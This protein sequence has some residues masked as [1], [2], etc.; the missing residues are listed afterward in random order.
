MWSTIG[1]HYYVNF[2]DKLTW[3]NWVYPLSKKLDLFETFI[4]FQ[5]L[6][7]LQ[8]DAKIKAFPI[9]KLTPSHIELPVCTS[10]NAPTCVNSAQLLGLRGYDN[11]LHLKLE[12]IGLPWRKSPLEV[13]FVVSPDFS[14]IKIFDSKCFPYFRDYRSRKLY[15]KSSPCI[16][17]D[18]PLTHD[19]Y[20]CLDLTSDC[21]YISRDVC[22]VEGDFSLY[23]YLNQQDDND[24]FASSLGCG[25]PLVLESPLGC[26]LLRLERNIVVV[27]TFVSNLPTTIQQDPFQ[28]SIEFLRSSVRHPNDTQQRKCQYQIHSCTENSMNELQYHS[29]QGSLIPSSLNTFV[30]LTKCYTGYSKPLYVVL[31]SPRVSIYAP[32]FS[33]T[34]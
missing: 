25:R 13:L 2:V 1:F 24:P 20:I 26:I 33:L 4:M 5:K 10:T 27:P 31:T 6:A 18:Y 17:L 9:L 12:P 11:N 22:F 19:K 15:P 30:S 32:Q 21:I 14:K 16:F 3:Y 8:C 23:A 29:H 34:I 7:K 28:D